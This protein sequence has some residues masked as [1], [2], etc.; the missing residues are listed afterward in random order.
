MKRLTKDDIQDAAIQAIEITQK[1]AIYGLDGLT[2]EEKKILKNTAW[3]KYYYGKR[4]KK[5]D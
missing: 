3:Y 2:K 5:K 4:R 1:F